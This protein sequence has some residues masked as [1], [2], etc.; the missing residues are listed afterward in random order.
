MK[1]K[2]FAAENVLRFY[3][4][5]RNTI[6]DM[7]DSEKL[8]LLKVD[9]KKVKTILDFG[10]AAGG[11]Y[12]ILKSIFTNCKYYCGMDSEPRMIKNA[13]KNF[14]KKS[15]R[16][17]VSNGKKI[18][19]KRRSFDLVFCT[20]CLNHNRNHKKIIEELFR[21]SSKYVFVDSPRVY[22]GKE[23]L[24]KIDLS[25]RFPS[26]IKEKNFV[27]NYTVNLKN[28]LFFLNKLFIKNDVKR[29]FLFFDKLPYKKTYLNINKKIYFLTF[30]C[31]KEFGYKN[32][33]QY[34]LIKKNN[35][36]QK[37]INQFDLS[38]YK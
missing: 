33:I 12:K 37:Y 16:F 6:K 25:K 17:L 22:E 31:E 29:V 30:L 38:V 11:F 20:G 1:T 13:R 23:F 2:Y 9:K 28:Y 21:V 14:N 34:K 36:I 10:C 26:N 32:K 24:G 15:T 8:P 4:K 35:V 19:F 3:I 27:N 18:N 7:Y 5:K